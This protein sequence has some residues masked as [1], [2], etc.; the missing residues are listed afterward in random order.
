MPGRPESLN[1]DEALKPATPAVPESRPTPKPAMERVREA[2][3]KV[4]DKGSN[5]TTGG[6]TGLIE[7]A[8]KH[9]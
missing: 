7:G 5:Y 3:A 6:A 8:L 4:A 1:I 9:F 2:V